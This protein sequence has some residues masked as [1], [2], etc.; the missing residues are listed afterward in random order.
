MIRCFSMV[1]AGIGAG[2]GETGSKVKENNKGRRSCR[3]SKSTIKGEKAQICRY[4]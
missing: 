3:W 4:V 2:A 1:G